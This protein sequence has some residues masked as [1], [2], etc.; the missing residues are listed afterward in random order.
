MIPFRVL[1]EMTRERRKEIFIQFCFSG[2]IDDIQG[3]TLAKFLSRSFIFWRKKRE[4]KIKKKKKNLTLDEDWMKTNTGRKEEIL[5][6]T[7]LLQVMMVFNMKRPKYA[8]AVPPI[9]QYHVK[10]LHICDKKTR[11]TKI[12]NPNGDDDI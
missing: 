12:L 6:R 5:F 2:R 7:H 4:K 1:S 10:Y 9:S 3:G 11:Y 8:S